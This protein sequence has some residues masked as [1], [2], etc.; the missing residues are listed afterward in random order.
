MSEMSDAM[1]IRRWIAGKVTQWIDNVEEVHW[2]VTHAAGFAVRGMD[3]ENDRDA[4]IRAVGEAVRDELR[5]RIRHEIDGG[6]D[7]AKFLIGLLEDV[8]DM[9]DAA[10]LRMLGEHFLPEPDAWPEETDEDRF[11]AANPHITPDD[12]SHPRHW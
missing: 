2:D 12:P 8:L 3:R 10:W 4:A 7:G 1:A 5:S 9:G 11:L 6:D